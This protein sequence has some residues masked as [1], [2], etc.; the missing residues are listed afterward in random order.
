[1]AMAAAP[2]LLFPSPL[3][4]EGCAALARLQAVPRRSWVRGNPGAATQILFRAT[5]R[6]TPHPTLSHKE[7]GSSQA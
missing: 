4:G 3:V 7:R 2:S 1:M 5:A 6:K